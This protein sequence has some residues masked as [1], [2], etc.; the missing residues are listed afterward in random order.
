MVNTL[1]YKQ[2]GG[3]FTSTQCGAIVDVLYDVWIR[4]TIRKLVFVLYEGARVQRILLLLCIVV[5]GQLGKM[6]TTS[7]LC[8]VLSAV[9]IAY[10]CYKR[11]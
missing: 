3:S 9:W 10:L 2:L 11:K 6:F 8:T 7:F 1:L 4:S 5:I